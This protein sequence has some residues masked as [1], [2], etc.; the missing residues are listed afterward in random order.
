VNRL[1][2]EVESWMSRMPEVPEYL[3]NTAKTA[4]Y[5]LWHAQHDPT[6]NYNYR[7]MFSSKNTWLTK[8]W[9]WDNCFH[10][11]AVASA[12][13]E[14]AWNQ[15]F[16][17]FDHQ[18]DNG[19]LPEPM[20]SIQKWSGWVKP[21]VYG[22]TIL[23]LIEWAGEEACKPYIERAYSPVQRLTSWWL[24]YRDFNNN[25]IASYLHGNDSGWDN[26]SAFDQGTPLE[27]P[28]LSAHLIKQMEALEKMARILGK[29]KEADDWQNKGQELL[30]KMLD[31]LVEDDLFIGKKSDGTVVPS[32]S[33]LYYIPILLGDR[34]PK[35][36]RKQMVKNLGDPEQFLT[37]YGLATEAVNSPEHKED[38]YWRGPIWGP[39]TYLVFD[40][41]ISA[42]ENKLA[43]MVA[44]RYCKMCKQ[45]PG[46]WEN[47]DATTGKGRQ[48][49]AV[50][51][52]SAV[53]ILF[54]GWLAK[55]Q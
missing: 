26:A 43:K 7:L 46:M 47:Y 36:I 15:M 52:T 27:S 34:L 13:L 45:D 38:G 6:G 35:S 55:S 32:Q 3:L 37:D 25:G 9:A 21:P 11:L 39:S 2:K 40:G 18:Y 49:P 12:D 5:Y 54:A 20:S 41:L 17:F 16:T 42:G 1:R 4:W 22:W 24:G 51:W 19:C 14:M 8:I 29:T 23:K 28:D 33:L 50:T 30:D 10:G 31:H 48:G 53:F 44:E